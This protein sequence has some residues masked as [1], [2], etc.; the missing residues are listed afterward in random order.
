MLRGIAEE[1]SI[2]FDTSQ[3][4]MRMKTSFELMHCINLT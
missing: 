1:P 3:S 2:Q 4:M